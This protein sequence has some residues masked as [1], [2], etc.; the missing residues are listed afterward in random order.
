MWEWTTTTKKH[1]AT[2][3]PKSYKYWN[4]FKEDDNYNNNN[5]KTSK[6]RT[7]EWKKKTIGWTNEASLE[8]R[9]IVRAKHHT[10]LYY[11]HNITILLLLFMACSGSRHLIQASHYYLF[12]WIYTILGTL[13]FLAIY[14]S[15]MIGIV[16]IAFAPRSPRSP[17]FPRSPRSPRFLSH[18]QSQARLYIAF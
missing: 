3:R 17:R 13:R 9:S 15:L 6:P 5:T 4:E 12:L 11:K 7:N 8:T 14:T 10:C 2:G 1:R 18:F 16:S